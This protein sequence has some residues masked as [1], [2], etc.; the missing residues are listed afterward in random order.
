[1]FDWRGA[2]PPPPPLPPPPHTSAPSTS[3]FPAK[4]FIVPLSQV[5]VGLHICLKDR[6][7]P[8]LSSP[9]KLIMNF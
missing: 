3:V 8:K 7:P 2:P 6:Q 1:M 4:S 9:S 5:G